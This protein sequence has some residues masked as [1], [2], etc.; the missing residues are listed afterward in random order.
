VSSC[1]LSGSG[2]S[3]DITEVAAWGHDHGQCHGHGGMTSPVTVMAM[4]EGGHDCKLSLSSTPSEDSNDSSTM[5]DGCGSNAQVPRAPSFPR[6]QHQPQGYMIN[7][8]G[9]V[10]HGQSEE[11]HPHTPTAA[12]AVTYQ[13]GCP[14][15]MYGQQFNQRPEH[16]GHYTA[17]YHHEQ[18]HIQH[19][20]SA[21]PGHHTAMAYCPAAN[22][23]EFYGNA[24][25]DPN[26][27]GYSYGPG[28]ESD[29]VPVASAYPTQQWH[30]QPLPYGHGQGQGDMLHLQW[31]VGPPVI[32]HHH[33]GHGYSQP[34]FGPMVHGQG[35]ITGSPMDHHYDHHEHDMHA[36]M[37]QA[38]WQQ[39][40]GH[41][42]APG[43]APRVPLAPGDY[44]QPPQGEGY[45]YG[46][47]Y[48]EAAP[49]GTPMAS[50]PQPQFQWQPQAY[51][52]YP[53]HH[54]H[55][56]Y[57]H[58]APT[59]ASV[60][61]HAHWQFPHQAQHGNWQQMPIQMPHLPYYRPEW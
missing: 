17:P 21:P 25:I 33:H 18:M 56:A 19:S 38:Q 61:W 6:L 26:S 48:P 22:G 60:P 4:A 39:M 11:H 46:Y 32:E 31:Q 8:V 41:E 51:E 16:Y 30:C 1:D 23:P 9:P 49:T 58:A 24:V 3:D 53:E 54:V 55:H 45:G 57:D 44:Y 34:Q 43:P 10:G 59:Q 15:T 35:S 36:P 47:G 14:N 20:D 12:A 40:Y 2:D 37:G 7:M 13:D 27:Y 29:Y 50:Q 42:P 5:A 52:C 28:M